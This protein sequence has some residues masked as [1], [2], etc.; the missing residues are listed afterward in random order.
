MKKF[1]R[2]IPKKLIILSI[3]YSI[4]TLLFL[5]NDLVFAR[6][7]VSPVGALTV[8]NLR[9][10]S[11]GMPVTNTRD[12][13]LRINAVDSDSEVSRIALANE[14]DLPTLEWFDW[15]GDSS[16]IETADEDIKN[17]SWQL[18]SGEGVKTIY[19]IVEDG[20][21][22]TSVTPSDSINFTIT[23]DLKG[24]QNGPENGI[25]RLGEE[26]V[27]PNV[28]PTK[29][30]YNFLGWDTEEDALD[31]K[32]D[33]GSEYYENENITFYAV[34]ELQTFAV[35]YNANAGN[36][37]VTDMP[38]DQIK[39]YDIPLEL[40]VDI[41]ER[42]G[43]I[44]AGWGTTSSATI[45][46]Y[47]P[48]DTYTSN[49]NIDL[50]AVWQEATATLTYD[51]NGCGTSPAPVTMKYSKK[52][53]AISMT[54]Q[55]YTLNSWNTEADGSGVSYNVGDTIKN[56]NVIPEDMTLYAQ[57]TEATAT[58]T[59]NANGHGTAPSSVTMKYSKV[60][61]AASM[62]NVSGYS[63]DGWNTDK[64][65]NGTSYEPKDVI[66]A[67]NVIPTKKTLYAIWTPN[68]LEVTIS[69]VDYN[70]FNWTITGS[71]ITGYAITTSSSVPTS[72]TTSSGAT[73]SGSYNITT[74]IS[75]GTTTYYVW[76]KDSAG[77]T[78]K[79]RIVAYEFT[80]TVGTG[81]TL[82]TRVDGTSSSTGTNFT[83][84]R[85]MLS[86]TKV[87]CKAAASTGYENPVLK[88][89]DTS[90]TASGY[91]ITIS[92]DTDV[93]SSATEKKAKL[94]YHLSSAFSSYQPAE[95]TMKYTKKTT[96]ASIS[97]P[98]YTFDKWYKNSDYSGTGIEAGGTVKA[99]DV[100][101]TETHLYGKITA[102]KYTLYLRQ[103]KGESSNGTNTLKTQTVTYNKSVTL[104][105]YSSISGTYPFPY[106][107]AYTPDDS[108]D[109][110]G[111]AFYGWANST[112]ATT[113]KYANEASFVYNKTDNM[114]L[115]A[116]GRRWFRFYSGVAPKTLAT[117]EYQYWN[118]YNTSNRTTIPIPNPT[119]IGS[120]W[121]FLG[122]AKDNNADDTVD[123]DASNAGKNVRVAIKK[124]NGSYRAV[125]SRKLTIVYNANGG[126][127]STSNSSATQYYNSGYAAETS[128]GSGTYANVGANVSSPA[129]TPRTCNFTKSGK[130]FAGWNTK[131]DG[132]GS[133]YQ[134][135][136][137]YK[138]F[139]PSVGNHTTTLTLYAN[140]QSHSW[141]DAT[142]TRA[143]YC[144]RCG[145]T[146][147]SALGHNPGNAATCT[148]GQTCT[149]CGITLRGPLGHNWVV[150]SANGGIIASWRCT[151]CGTIKGS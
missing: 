95:V 100:V 47:N 96:A 108:S 76:A 49:S 137:S 58:L 62:S 125:Y 14:V 144:S 1:F 84:N 80:R 102:N 44:F 132:T 89:N 40:E 130:C 5:G 12:V 19:L 13:I 75:N 128:S 30:G 59:Y 91:T 126:T 38:E 139:S 105:A 121:S 71:N 149:R 94:Y 135:G 79:A 115:Y 87:W 134:A 99:A 81:S 53:T 66:K 48:G 67:A 68:P 26:Y 31:A 86:G 2:M 141:V 98:G 23:Y 127:G 97:I 72:W 43:Y 36:D 51:S 148:R 8:E 93:V 16:L 65:G 61:K 29:T 82:T 32:Y 112:S 117:A 143:K 10:R 34:W 60:T 69:R 52:I 78:N 83:T 63:F 46:Q 56:A 140:W 129:F 15:S 113:R 17:K 42:Y 39:E 146:S 111:F 25:K 6:D 50:Y 37:E 119:S 55:G 145:T 28:I 4:F 114:N 150:N 45:V 104:P 21:G 123:I 22:N 109:N 133:N 88:V 57:C 118:P 35:I 7:D 103:G 90:R 116:I 120:E 20:D 9:D 110:Y 122:Y 70:T 77:K 151:R 106:S 136:T 138:L 33:A 3:I 92:D 85:L 124:K 73:V 131:K 74:T 142:C 18:S 101:P 107:S 24:G 147:G 54:N 27:I 11:D 41:P 64:N